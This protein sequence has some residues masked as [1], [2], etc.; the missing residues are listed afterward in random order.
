MSPVYDFSRQAIDRSRKAGDRTVPGEIIQVNRAMFETR[1]NRVVTQKA[2]EIPNR[3]L[4]AGAGE[5]AGAARCGR[6]GSRRAYRSGHYERGLTLKAGK[7]AVGVPKPR[8]GAVSGSAVIERYRRREE[9]VEEALID[10]Y[11]AGV[12]TRRVD[13]ISRALWGE[14]M[15]SRT[16]PDRL[17]RVCED[18]DAWRRRPLAQSYPYVSMD[19]VWHER[20]WGGAVGNV[21][22]PVAIGVRADGRRGSSA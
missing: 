15:P 22:A 14:R 4:G 9:P 11:L 5:T 12:P 8:G 20:G 19:G 6:S 21:S 18:I 17:E 2:T 10:M 13:G 3:M 7:M 16:L 1:S